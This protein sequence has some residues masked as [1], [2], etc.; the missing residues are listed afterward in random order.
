ML[1]HFIEGICIKSTN[2]LEAKQPVINYVISL[3]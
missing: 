1:L 2:I 3:L